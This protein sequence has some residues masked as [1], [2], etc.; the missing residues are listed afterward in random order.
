MT[1]PWKDIKFYL[2]KINYSFSKD[3]YGAKIESVIVR[4]DQ[5]C[6]LILILNELGVHRA[7]S[8]GESY[9]FDLDEMGRVKFFKGTASPDMITTGYGD[10]PVSQNTLGDI[11]ISLWVDPN[12]EQIVVN[13]RTV[14]SIL[15]IDKSGVYRLPWAMESG[16]P[17]D[18][19]GRIKVVKT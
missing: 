6:G 16:L 8:V 7:L 17:C 12:A 19:L 3:N 1:K 9:G 14:Y 2:D 13:V 11:D 10:S 15:V 4:S 5:T 18:D